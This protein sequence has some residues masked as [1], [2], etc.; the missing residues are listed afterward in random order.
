MHFHDI[1][2]LLKSF[3][4]LIENGHSILVIE[5]NPDV[6]KCADWLIDLGLEGGKNGGQLIFEG[7]PEEAIN[8]KT[9]ATGHFLREK[10]ITNNKSK[11]TLSK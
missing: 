5:H 7:L 9:S 2:K 11:K 1:K 8:C 6:I 10:M 3:N 4:A